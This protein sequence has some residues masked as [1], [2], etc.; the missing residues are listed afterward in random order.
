[1]PMTFRPSHLSTSALAIIL[2]FGSVLTFGQANQAKLLLDKSIEFH[3]PSD[4]WTT[5]KGT[6]NL[7][8]LLPDSSMRSEE[9]YMDLTSGNFRHERKHEGKT[10]KRVLS[11]DVCEGSLNGMVDLPADTLTKYRLTCESIT[12]YRNYYE[13]LYGLPMKLKDEG[14]ILDPTVLQKTFK[15]NTYDVI[16]VTYDPEVG[17][18]IWYF[19]FDQQT[20]EMKIYQFFHEEEKNDGEY[21]LLSGLHKQGNMKLPKDRA[22][23]MNADDRFLATDMLKQ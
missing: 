19:Y 22:W 4:Q 7:S 6:L 5:F 20:H 17:S 9:V 8:V 10:Y 16:R 1:M 23:F 12:M 21:I 14:T 2:L 15:G 11:G 3:D 18:D 13:Y